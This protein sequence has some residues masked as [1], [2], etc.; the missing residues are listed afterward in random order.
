MRSSGNSELD[1]QIYQKT[2][3]EVDIRRARGPLTLSELV[4][5]LGSRTVHSRTVH[6]S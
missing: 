3:E 6:R 2:P 4:E 1:E 5:R